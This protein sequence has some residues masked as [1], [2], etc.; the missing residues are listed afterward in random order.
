MSLLIPPVDCS[1]NLNQRSRC[2]SI[3][4]GRGRFF[5]CKYT[6]VEFIL[7]GKIN[8]TSNGG[9]FVLE[10]CKRVEALYTFQI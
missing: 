3:A 8:F 9:S 6:D 2:C 10:P 1:L 7:D 5:L 4:F